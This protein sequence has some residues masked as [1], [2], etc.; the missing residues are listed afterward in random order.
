MCVLTPSPV[1]SAP[2]SVTANSVSFSCVDVS[3]TAPS[4][5]GGGSATITRYHI[6][7]SGG[8][9][10]IEDGTST[11]YQVMGLTPETSYSFTVTAEN[12]CDMMSPGATAA[13]ATSTGGI[14]MSTHST[15]L[16]SQVYNAVLCNLKW[17]RLIYSLRL[18]DPPQYGG[19]QSL[20]L[21]QT[22]IPT[23]DTSNCIITNCVHIYMFLL[24]K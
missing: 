14:E 6:T 9:H 22:P 24:L 1:P 16:R 13:M 2:Q 7:W 11:N 12:S 5:A 3:W 4:S 15:L 18:I 19:A 8:S 17:A 23:C 10:T 20:T 21:L